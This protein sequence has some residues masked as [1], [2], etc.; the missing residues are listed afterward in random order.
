VNHTNSFREIFDTY[1]NNILAITY[2][3][4]KDWGI[5]EDITQEVFTKYWQQ[6]NQFRQESSLKTYLIRAAI[7][8]SKDHLKSWRYRTH[9]LTNRFLGNTR[10]KSELV[11]QE[12]HALLANAVF[13]L[14]VELR[15]IIILYFYQYYTYKEIAQV[16]Q[17]PESTI[18]NRMNK[19]KAL[20]K[21]KLP[22]EEWEVLAYE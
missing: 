13:E 14:P 20:L 3:Y 8:R 11:E 2:T 19:A 6:Q 18:K 9:L 5:A 16:L 15:E 12:E 1:A 7:N 21:Q 4:V 10:D 22:N 17:I